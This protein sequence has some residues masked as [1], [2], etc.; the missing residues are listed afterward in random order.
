VD[1]LET[2]KAVLVRVAVAGVA[3]R[4]VRV[5]LEGQLLCI[6]GTRSQPRGDEEVLRH[7]QLEI[8]P[9]PFEARVR[10]PI[11]VERDQV[12]ARLEDGVLTVRL[13][14]RAARRIEVREE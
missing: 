3:S 5:A 14:K 4:D 10:I 9:G 6:R 7:H 13:P 2:E 1:V 8:E 11:A 12:S